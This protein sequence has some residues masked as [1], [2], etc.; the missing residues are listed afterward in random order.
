MKYWIPPHNPPPWEKKPF[1]LLTLSS[2]IIFINIVYFL[3]LKF[4]LKIDFRSY[5][6]SDDGFILFSIIFLFS[7]F[8]VSI[9][10][11]FWEIKKTL[12][13]YWCFWQ[14]DLLTK[15]IKSK[16]DKLYLIYS[17]II[18]HNLTTISDFNNESLF[19]KAESNSKLIDLEREDI[20][21]EERFFYIV[22]LLTN[23]IKDI[24]I[25]KKEKYF[26]IINSLFEQSD[27]IKD[28]IKYFLNGYLINYEIIF[29]AKPN[30][31]NQFNVIKNK[32]SIT[33]IF[34][35][36]Y[37][38]LNTNEKNEF[39]SLII[40]SSSKEKEFLTLFHPMPFKMENIDENI[41]TMSLI[42]QQ[43]N[44]DIK[45]VNFIDIEKE[46]S[47]NI[48]LKLRSEN[49]YQL[50]LET[51]TQ[52]YFFNEY[53]D[54]Y[55]ELSIYHLLALIYLSKFKD[56]S[57]ILFYKLDKNYYCQTIGVQKSHIDNHYLNIPKPSFPLGTLLVSF[58]ALTSVIF[59]NIIDHIEFNSERIII[60]SASFLF[61]II[62]ISVIKKIY[63]NF[64]WK[65]HFLK[66]LNKKWNL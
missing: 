7:L 66:T 54:N 62:I 37:Y 47:N 33:L 22:K 11:L 60:T 49:S 12:Y 32:K 1:P 5:I 50:S 51:Y 10:V 28:K 59:N 27:F 41:K 57:Q 44:K 34:S 19:E 21:G 61:T 9:Y 2:F 18:S 3:I 45:Q 36:N 42:Q 56:T 15:W 16:Q 23:S 31:D 25:S 65:I 64:Y 58:F 46:N 13:I 26:V 39:S 14:A 52:G 20:V 63:I 40:L 38:A 8:L 43:Q 4:S 53:I 17:N 30:Y 6:T 24:E 29:Q 55:K 48:I 35:I